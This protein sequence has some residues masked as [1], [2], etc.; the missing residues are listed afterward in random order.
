MGATTT[1]RHGQ[2]NRQKH[3]PIAKPP[4]PAFDHAVRLIHAICG[5]AGSPTLIDD[6]RADL[7]ADKARAAI[8]HR[9]TAAVF[10]WLMAALSYQGIADAVAYD[11]G[12][13]RARGLAG[14]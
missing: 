7:T 14:H 12:E 10:D 3:P 5:L 8:R 2:A 4:A 9:D 13:T 11:Y 1:I 6:I